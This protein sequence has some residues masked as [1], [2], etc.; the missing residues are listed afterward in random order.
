MTINISWAAIQPI[1]MISEESCD[2]ADLSNC[3]WEFSFAI[4][5]INHILKHSE[6]E[7]SYLKL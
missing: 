6:I 2:I 7:I 1:R 4:T 5:R 3:G